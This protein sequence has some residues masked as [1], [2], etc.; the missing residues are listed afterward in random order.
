MKFAQ[1]AYLSASEELALLRAAKAG[2]TTALHKIVTAHIPLVQKF[3]SVTFRCSPKD[4]RFEDLC[5]DGVLGLYDAVEKF[6][7]DFK[8]R[9][10]T[11][12]IYH[13][14]V[15]VVRAVE[16]NSPL[17]EP[18]GATSK[19]RLVL[20]VERD[21]L[22][23]NPS[24][25]PTHKAIAALGC[26]STNAVQ[27]IRTQSGTAAHSLNEPVGFDAESSDTRGDLTEDTEH[28]SPEEFL[29]AKDELRCAEKYVASLVTKVTT[30]FGERNADI[31]LRYH[32]LGK[33]ER[34]DEGEYVLDDVAR[35][36][37]ITRERVRQI[38]EA[39]W[40][41]LK[42]ANRSYT[43]EDLKRIRVAL[44]LLPELTP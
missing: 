36:H 22:K 29:V 9:F 25:Y 14:R 16:S 26:L 5:Q 19:R 42:K 34:D 18:L 10:A 21:L 28:L 13:V 2:E 41:K 20:R 24:V 38:V 35:A 30:A 15:C 32:S 39:C 1:S 8:V 40:T 3:V 11:Y 31:F 27:R 4:Q 17:T 33:Y 7:L 43:K 12:A 6:D 37:N 44:L 23:K